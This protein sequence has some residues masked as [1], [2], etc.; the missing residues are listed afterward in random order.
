[1][2]ELVSNDGIKVCI[3]MTYSELQIQ[4]NP[5][6]HPGFNFFFVLRKSCLKII[7]VLR[8][9]LLSKLGASTTHEP[10]QGKKN[11][12]TFNWLVLYSREVGFPRLVSAVSTINRVTNLVKLSCIPFGQ[13]PIATSAQFATQEGTLTG[14]NHKNYF[15]IW[16]K[17]WLS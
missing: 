6:S 10:V 7:F 13:P 15:F 3:L 1:M 12:I 4:M 17:Q 8:W 5:T 16:I 14:Q 9:N 2:N 11:I